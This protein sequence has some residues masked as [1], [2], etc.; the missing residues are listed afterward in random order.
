MLLLFFDT[1]VLGLVSSSILARLNI[2]LVA[3]GAVFT[4]SLAALILRRQAI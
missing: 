1:S 2:V 3:I 4:T